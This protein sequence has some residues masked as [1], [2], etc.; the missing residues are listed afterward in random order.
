MTGSKLYCSKCSLPHDLDVAPDVG[1]CT[2]C[3]GMLIENEGELGK[4]I[5]GKGTLATLLPQFKELLGK[6]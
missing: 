1:E 4:D 3:G 2:T 5:L 6:N